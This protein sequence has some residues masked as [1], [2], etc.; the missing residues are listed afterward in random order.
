MSSLKIIVLSIYFWFANSAPNLVENIAN[1]SLV[2]HLLGRTLAMASSPLSSFRS[3]GSH[4]ERERE[5]E[6][7][8]DMTKEP[9]N[10]SPL[11]LFIQ[12]FFMYFFFSLFFF[13]HAGF[14]RDLCSGSPNKAGQCNRRFKL[15]CFQWEA[16]DEAVEEERVRSISFFLS[17]IIIIIIILSVI[18][19]SCVWGSE[20]QGG[21]SWFSSGEFISNS[22]HNFPARANERLPLTGMIINSK[23][24][25]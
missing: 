25:W 1:F 24:R 12:S 8:R 21:L 23:H 7:A 4:R 14:P 9:T 16:E 3:E 15:Q 2:T 10:R 13:N 11:P 5:R 20:V 6:N 18:L 17:P 19:L 22:T